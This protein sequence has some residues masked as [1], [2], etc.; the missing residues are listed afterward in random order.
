MFTLRYYS[1]KTSDWHEACRTDKG[2][3]VMAE[4]DRVVGKRMIPVLE[5]FHEG[6]SV[7]RLGL[8]RQGVMMLAVWKE[9]LKG[10]TSTFKTRYEKKRARG[11]RDIQKGRH[12]L[13]DALVL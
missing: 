8:T 5:L 13:L 6:E 3:V 11:V 10:A 2:R 4:Y 9:R 1:T 12:L 7:L